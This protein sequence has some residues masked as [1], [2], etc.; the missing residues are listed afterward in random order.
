MACCGGGGRTLRKQFVQRSKGQAKL[1]PVK[2]MSKAP[3]K[4]IPVQRQAIVRD[5]RCPKCAYPIMLVHIAGRERRQCS[6][7]QCKHVM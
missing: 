1:T 4:S 3:T 2:R 5:D 6:N 7:S